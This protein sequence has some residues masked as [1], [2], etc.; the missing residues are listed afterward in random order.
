MPKKLISSAKSYAK[1][2]SKHV[3]RV[4]TRRESAQEAWN[5]TARDT[6][7]LKRALQAVGH[8]AQHDEAIRLVKRGRR[9]YNRG[10]YEEAEREFRE[11]IRTDKRCALAYTYLGF[12][13]Y[14]QNRVKAA[15]RYW[16]QAIEI[17]PDSEAA[18]KARKKIAYVNRR[19]SDAKAWI[20]DRLDGF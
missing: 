3:G 2:L 7:K 14:K 9:E 17:S 19:S 5:Q 6:K 16:E 8:G 12:S 18:E 4:V 13:L 15:V 10:D 1:N 11:A 20:R